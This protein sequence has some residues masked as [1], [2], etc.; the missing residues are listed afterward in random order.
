M[1]ESKTLN[2]NELIPGKR[3]TWGT[4][5]DYYFF[6][7]LNSTGH[8][9]FEGR[10]CRTSFTASPNLD[11]QLMPTVKKKWVNIY[12]YLDGRVSSGAVLHDTREEAYLRSPPGCANSVQIELTIPESL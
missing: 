4:M 11:Y 8:P 7:G 2:V 3:Y 5:R 1:H 12:Y 6:V 10:G 9:V